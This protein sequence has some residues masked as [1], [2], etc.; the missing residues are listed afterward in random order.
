VV[1]TC[2][3]P[4]LCRLLVDRTLPRLPTLPLRSPTAQRTHSYK[5]SVS[6]I[7]DFP[8]F[9]KSTLVSYLRA[10]CAAPKCPHWCYSD[11]LK[12]ES[13]EDS[14]LLSESLTHTHAH[15]HTFVTAT[16]LVKVL[17]WKV[18]NITNSADN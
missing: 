10:V 6:Q 11:V 13:L 1:K 9:A 7:K 16:I 8:L 3:F 2:V 15:A 5:W 18:L 17:L 14:A 12:W 4:E